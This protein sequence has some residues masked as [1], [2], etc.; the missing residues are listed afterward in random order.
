MV[1]KLPQAGAR[2]ALYAQLIRFEKPIGFY[3]LLWPTLWALAVSADGAPDG[4]I[5][6]VFVVGV[7]LMRSAGCAINDYADRDFDLKVSRT[8]ER[9]LTSGKISTRE[10]LMV[11]ALLALLS[12]LLVLSL[13]R[14]TIM[15][16]FVGIVLA[17]SYPYMK[18]FHYLPQ[19]HLGAAFGWAVP[20]AFA[21]QTGSLPKQAWLLYVATLL[22]AVAYDTMYS[23]VDREDDLKLG[24]KSTAILFGEYDR[25]M[26]GV[27][28]LMFMIALIL[29]GLDLGL[30]GIYFVGLGVAALLLGFQQFLIADRAPAHCFIAFLNNH[31]V[32]AAVFAGLIAHYYLL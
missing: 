10:A 11:F 14:F 12:F 3:L 30:S 25:L 16:S 27:F 22:W 5:L 31:W 17:A 6:F 24:I 28:Q 23:M 7:F 29:I 9:P 32:G 13:N 1:D 4:W 26:V 20:M 19:V 2:L 8:R 15:L 21:A 18:R